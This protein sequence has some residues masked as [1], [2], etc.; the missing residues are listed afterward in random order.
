MPW[1]NGVKNTNSSWVICDTKPSMW[2]F[3]TELAGN[4]QAEIFSGH[5]TESPGRLLAIDLGAAR[6]GVAVCDDLRISIRPLS[7]IERRSWKDLLRRVFALIETYEA[8]GLV[9]GLPLT[10]KGEE[11]QASKEARKMADKF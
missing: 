5:S 1:R 10:L 4:Q 9:I 2:L 3:I 6:I 11:G 8:K 7:M